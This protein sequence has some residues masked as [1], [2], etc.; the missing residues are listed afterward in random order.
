MRVITFTVF[1]ESLSGQNLWIYKVEPT[2]SCSAPGV[3]FLN[4]TRILY[5]A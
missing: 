2:L 3:T 1:P 5:P 4:S